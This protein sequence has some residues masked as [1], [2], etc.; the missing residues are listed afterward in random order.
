MT[1][2][3]SLALLVADLNAQVRQLQAEITAL[4][5]QQAARGQE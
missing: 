2:L 5:E 4:R 3:E 1:P